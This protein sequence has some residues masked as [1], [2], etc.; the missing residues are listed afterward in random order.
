MDKRL[1]SLEDALLLLKD[2]HEVTNF[3]YDLCTPKEWR[4]LQERWRV[5]QLLASGTYSYRDIYN[6]TGVSL[7]TIARVA[8]FLKDE[9]RHGYQTV[10]K[11]MQKKE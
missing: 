11:R 5:C 7:T 1:T 2:P 4:A 10:L 6:L 8:R 9:P 3:F